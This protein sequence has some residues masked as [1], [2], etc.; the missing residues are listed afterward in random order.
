VWPDLVL[1]AVGEGVDLV[2]DDGCTKHRGPATM[3]QADEEIWHITRPGVLSE[4][5]VRQAASRLV[6]FVCTGN[7]CRSPLAEALF[8]K[9]LADRLDCSVDQLP[10][11]GFQVM[12]A[13]VAAGAGGLAA[14]EAVQVARDYGAD[15]SNHRSRFLTPELAARADY[16]IAMTQGHLHSLLDYYPALGVAPR[17]LSPEGEDL[18]DPIGQSRDVYIACGQA[19]WGYLD[20]LMTEINP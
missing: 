1:A 6:V 19:I 13:G 14:A 2:V 20:R 4:E 15:L 16:L 17:L 5:Q 10:G 9:R 7:T 18:A 3:V 8:K 12:S 11:R